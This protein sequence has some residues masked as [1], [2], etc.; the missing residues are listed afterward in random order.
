MGAVA[1]PELG[2]LLERAVELQALEDAFV[3]AVAGRGRL[4]LVSG[5]AGAGK[6]ALVRR[7][8]E[9]G[10]GSAR[11]LW[12]V[13]DALFT[14]RPLGPLVEIADEVG[15]ELD[16]AVRAAAGSHDVAGALALEL[17]SRSPTVLVLEDVHWADEATLDVLKLVG[18]QIESLPA[19]LVVTYRDDE[20]EPTHPLRHLL[21]RLVARGAISR[22]SVARLS[23]EAVAALARPHGVVDP[24]ELYGKTEGNPFFVTEILAAPGEEIPATVRDAVLARCSRLGREAR[25]LLEAVAVARTTAELWLLETL[26][27]DELASLDECLSS[28]MLVSAP[29]SVG[30]RHELARL[31]IEES[32]TPARSV[33]LHERALA[34]LSAPPVGAPDL[35]RLAHHAEAA[36]DVEAVICHAPAAAAR[37]AKL[38]SHREAAAQ[39]ARALRYADGVSLQERAQLHRRRA[40]E[41]YLTDQHDEA[42]GSA[43]AA[44]ACYRE[45]GDQQGEG[46]S[47]LALSSIAWCPGRTAEA[48]RAARE[49]VEILERLPRG[50]ELAQAYGNLAHRRLEADDREGAIE[51]A[52]RAR[53]LAEE[54][55]DETL[56][57]EQEIT[58]GAAELLHDDA[59]GVAKLERVLER[60]RRLGSEPVIA[61]SF[62]YL[63]RGAARQ[64]IY[65]IA[66]RA[67]RDGLSFVGE[68]GYLLWRLYLLAYRARIELEQGLWSEAADTAE[69]VL[70]ERWISTQPR[71]IA[72]TVLGLVRARRGDPGW[73]GLVDEAWALADG[74]GEPERIAPVAAAR[75]EVA[76]LE[77]RPEAALEATQ[78]ALE[79]SRRQRV[80]RFV[81]ELAA[82]RLRAGVEGEAPSEAAEPYALELA[83]D[84]RGAADVWQELGCPYE[85]ALA[86][87]DAEDDDTLRAALGQLHDLGAQPAAAIVA[88]RLRERGARGIPIGPRPATRENPAGLTPREVEV[89]ALVAEGLHNAEIAERLV[90]SRRTVD[91]HVSA[92]LRKLRVADRREAAAEARRLGLIAKDR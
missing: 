76:W 33:F 65:P 66:W 91:H 52:T 41:C 73:R 18:R 85:Q 8:C 71:T 21:G 14:P 67:A 83:G 88:R 82:W 81:A 55:G 48:E 62:I 56:V 87:A 25:A 72:L 58:V 53:A 89:L 36:G 84:W 44:I 45:L 69:L 34:A 7:F 90:V 3:D 9:Q 38:G 30:F 28:G 1:A 57:C 50:R 15:A 4:V 47:V 92:I 20:L 51:W 64:R 19:L 70:G 79:L 35:A 39:Y 54:I 31:T 27:A 29:A 78:A 5:E 37:A 13:C 61:G 12:G 59:G 2:G 6:T 46:K 16:A 74:T 10:A 42:I 86:L 68:R 32:L 24:D 43:Q 22:L 49:A 80:P 23:R 60:G 26:A 77:G 63:A 11:I 75:A 17:Q 40:R